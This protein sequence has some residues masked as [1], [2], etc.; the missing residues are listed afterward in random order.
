VARR[1]R[2]TPPP[3][4]PGAPMS[5]PTPP[6]I[7][8]LDEVTYLAT[9][10]RGT[11]PALDA[12]LAELGVSRRREVPGGIE[13]R[14]GI[15]LAMRVCLWSRIAGRVL[16]ELGRDEL[17]N[18]R[19]LYP[20]V[21]S[22]P[23]GGF[24]DA[25]HTLAVTFTAKSGLVRNT[26]FAAMVVKDAIV[27]H[28]RDR[29]GR[30]PDV[31]REQ[32]DVRMVVN[33]REH[34]AVYYIEL[35]G[36]PL[37][38]RGYRLEQGEAPLK[39]TLAAALLRFARWDGRRPL[40]DPFCGTGTIVLEAAMI[41]T[42]M[43][44]GLLRPMGFERWPFFAERMA[45]AWAALR[46]EATQRRLPKVRGVIGG[47]DRDNAVIT[48][49]RANAARAGIDGIVFFHGDARQL[50]PLRG[51]GTLV[52]NPPWGERMGREGASEELLGEFAARWAT[53]TDHTLTMAVTDPAIRAFGRKADRLAKIS[54]GKIP[55]RFAHYVAPASAEA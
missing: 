27:D 53:F 18:E 30:R 48:T 47:S 10:I 24:F 15:E 52:A 50:S 31:D 19:Q 6:A 39:E 23:L 33:L 3:L 28:V 17:R 20:S 36:A 12:E 42:D 2:Y 41:A 11:E 29:Q 13:F 51:G 7:P 26:M 44:P 38:H 22:L 14:G 4:L 32:P 5:A 34:L 25:D 45:P 21:R 9:A 49:A 8:D 37:H 1:A 55:L 16:L 40:H 35:N 46:D 54:H 43:A